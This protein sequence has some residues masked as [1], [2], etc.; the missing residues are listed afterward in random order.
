[1]RIEEKMLK[2]VIVCYVW[3]AGAKTMS[4]SRCK[5]GMIGAMRR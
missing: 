2:D 5:M 4:V 3:Q 1:M